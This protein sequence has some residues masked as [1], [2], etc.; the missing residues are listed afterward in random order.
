MIE[1]SV[2]S[3]DRSYYEG[4]SKAITLPGADG[5]F[6]ILVGHA[7]ILAQLKKGDIIIETDEGRKSIKINE[8]ML[9]FKDNHATVLVL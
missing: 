3:P 2:K 9:D 1:I 8:G 4:T 7:P 5:Q 6:Q